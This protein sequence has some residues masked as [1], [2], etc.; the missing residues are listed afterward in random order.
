MAWTNH[1]I[2]SE[3]LTEIGMGSYV[4]DAQ[5]EDLQT[6]QGR[7]D[8]MLAEWE[9]QGII[10]G[11]VV[12]NTPTLADLQVDAGIRQQLVRPVILNLALELG[13]MFGKTVS[14]DTKVAAKKGYNLAVASSVT[15]PTAKAN[16]T[17]APAGG[18]WK[19][20][21]IPFLAEDN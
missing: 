20:T 18:G 21:T 6:A 16:V 19:N 4:Y 7:L 5:P 12:K 8:A 14:P 1:Q 3:A 2:I 10:T 15:I 13:P 11:Y 9:S 17:S